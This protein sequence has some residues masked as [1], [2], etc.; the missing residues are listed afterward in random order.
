VDDLLS[1]NKLRDLAR[2]RVGHMARWR[3]YSLYWASLGVLI[4]GLVWLYVHYFLRSI[5]SF[6]FE[7]PH[8]MEK[9]ALIAH[10]VCAFYGLWW[11]G[12]LWPN[13]IYKSWRAR[14]RRLSGGAL[15]ACVVWLTLTGLALYY[16]GTE[17][18]R[19]FTSLLHWIGGLVC[20]AA[21]FVHLKTRSPR[22]GG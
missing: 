19:S 6:G 1:P 7:G 15:F 12:L 11:F 3:R 4:T 21:F 18:L 22:S 5:D 10:A 14:I 17:A 13:H 8:P 20:A 2:A 16:L 9:W